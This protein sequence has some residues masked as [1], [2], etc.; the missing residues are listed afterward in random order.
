[1]HVRVLLSWADYDNTCTLCTAEFVI[2]PA[3]TCRLNSSKV[4]S[5]KLQKLCRKTKKIKMMKVACNKRKSGLGRKENR[6]GGCVALS[7]V[8][9]FSVTGH[10][11]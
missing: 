10:G 3:I 9:L 6:L 5:D 4:A 2:V 11:E 1:M 7:L 8:L